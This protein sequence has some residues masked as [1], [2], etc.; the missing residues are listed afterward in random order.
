MKQASLVRLCK[1]LKASLTLAARRD[2]RGTNRTAWRDGLGGI[3]E[4]YVSRNTQ[5]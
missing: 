2:T 4:D 3:V 5:P 1:A